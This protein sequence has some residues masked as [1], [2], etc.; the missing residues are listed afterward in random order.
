ME[1]CTHIEIS[2]G[3]RLDLFT[4]T[5][6]RV[7]ISRLGEERFPVH[8]EIPFAV[9]H[10][11]AWATV[12]YTADDRSDSTMVAVRTA[13]LC[14]Y[15]RKNTGRF[16]VYSLDGVRLYPVEAPKFGMFANHCVV[17]D[18]ASHFNEY[19][20]CSRY[21]H[22]FYNPET[23]LYDIPLAEDKLFDTYFL[24]GENYKDCYR[25]YNELVGA[26]PML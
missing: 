14:I 12:N 15:V 6:F 24:W 16:M 2:E 26:E 8:Y 17:F 1:Y 4:E 13:K 9:G 25:Q 10:T 5:C 23:G 18:A 20:A 7:R 11:Q 19:S 3:I 21:C 22:W